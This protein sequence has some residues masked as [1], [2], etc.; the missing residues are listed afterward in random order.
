MS[1]LA[2]AGLTVQTRLGY[3]VALR[4]FLLSVSSQVSP[5]TS[6]SAYKND[7][8]AMTAHYARLS[9]RHRHDAA[10]QQHIAVE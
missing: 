4:G 7:S 3:L 5:S 1:H 9:Q 2:S 10:S 6:C 8:H